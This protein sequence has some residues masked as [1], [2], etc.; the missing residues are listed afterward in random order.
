M[1]LFHAFL[2]KRSEQQKQEEEKRMREALRSKEELERERRNFVQVVARTDS[3]ARV[4]E[5]GLLNTWDDAMSIL[6]RDRNG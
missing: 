1:N 2:G 5:R 6:A 4:I 3:A